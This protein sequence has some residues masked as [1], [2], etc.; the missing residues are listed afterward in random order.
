MDWP[1][2]VVVAG[3]HN[4][5]SYKVGIKQMVKLNVI[6]GKVRSCLHRRL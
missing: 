3:G 1:D 4:W 2:L 6:I 5:G